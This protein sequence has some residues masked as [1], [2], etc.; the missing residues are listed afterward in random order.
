M[1]STNTSRITLGSGDLYL[2]NIHVGALKGNVSFIYNGTIKKFRSQLSLGAKKVFRIEEE[3]R[4]I[5]QIAEIDVNNFKL[6]LGVSDSVLSSQSFPAYDPTSYSVPSGASYDIMKFGGS[7][8]VDTTSLRFVH[9]IPGTNKYIIIILYS[10][11]SAAQWTIPFN[12]QTVTLQKVQFEALIDITRNEGDQMGFIAHQIDPHFKI[13]KVG[14]H[15]YS[16]DL[17]KA[18]GTLYY[19]D[20]LWLLM[21]EAAYPENPVKIDRTDVSVYSGV[22]GTSLIGH[23]ELCRAKG[24]IW[25]PK[26]VAANLRRTLITNVADVTDYD[27][28]AEGAGLISNGCM[29][30]DS[31]TETIFWGGRT[32]FMEVN[33]SNVNSPSSTWHD[34][35]TPLGLTL[36]SIHTVS[37]DGTYLYFSYTDGG[38]NHGL[39]KVKA[40]DPSSGG[41]TGWV[42][43]SYI[44]PTGFTDDSAYYNG[45]IYIASDP[46]ASLDPVLLKIDASDL[47]EVKRVKLYDNNGVIGCYGVWEHNGY[48]Y[49]AITTSPG[50]IKVYNESLLLIY[51]YTFPSG[52]NLPNEIIF[53]DTDQFFVTM[54]SSPLIIA[55]MRLIS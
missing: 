5:A 1:E 27:F 20:Y 45:Y 31:T 29:I 36:S 46:V 3:S 39:C 38:S 53:T 2:N 24:Y 54:W 34:M 43:Q 37:S 22:S 19:D 35:N 17:G 44:V 42:T 4:L 21:S 12:E 8:T 10:C 51:E 6:A 23:D 48:I 14:D 41:A 50:K 55:E 15:T 28:T 18:H 13:E 16:S 25:S 7:K 26:N 47:S 40:S 9:Q 52:F 33:I 11:Y 49:T 30:Y 32:G